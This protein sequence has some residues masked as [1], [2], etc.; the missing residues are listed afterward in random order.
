[1][2]KYGVWIFDEE[3]GCNQPVICKARNEAEARRIG[4]K[5]IA[6]WGL[7]GGTITEVREVE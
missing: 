2:K 5:Y 1:M 7:I 3:S 4:K 6:S